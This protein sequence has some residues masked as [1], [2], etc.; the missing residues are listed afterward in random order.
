MQSWMDTVF[1]KLRGY[2][3]KKATRFMQ[4]AGFLFGLIAWIAF[5]ILNRVQGGFLGILALLV[6]ALAFL[7]RGRLHRE[8]GWNMRPFNVGMAIGVGVGLVLW[9]AYGAITGD[10]FKTVA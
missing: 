6:F 8:T 1:E 4:I 7:A 5:I 2:D 10:L 3:E 9:T